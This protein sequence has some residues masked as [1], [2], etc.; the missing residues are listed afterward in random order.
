MARGCVVS[1]GWEKAMKNHVWSLKLA[2]AV[3]IMVASVAFA[4]QEE[5]SSGLGVGNPFAK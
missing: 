4:G 3:G 1:N 5:K 2:A